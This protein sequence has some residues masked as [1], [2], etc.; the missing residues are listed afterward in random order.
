[1]D[2]CS[3]FLGSKISV[4]KPCR[5][6]F[7]VTNLIS[8]SKQEFLCEGFVRTPVNIDIKFI[9]PIDI[10]CILINTEVRDR[11]ISGLKLFANTKDSEEHL[12]P[13]SI[14]K[15]VEVEIESSLNTGSIIKAFKTRSFKN[16]GVSS[17]Q[18]VLTSVSP[19]GPPG[20]KRLQIWGQPTLTVSPSLKSNIIKLW[21]SRSKK[22]QCEKINMNWFNSQPVKEEDNSEA[23]K[24]IS[25]DGEKPIPE[26]F[27]DI[28][29]CEVM[30]LPIL[31]PSGNSI[32]SSSLEKFIAIEAMWGRSPSDPFT[33]IPFKE[34]RKPEPNILLKA[35]IDSDINF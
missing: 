16:V 29:T 7:S 3:S 5:D 10:Y 31:L 34:N 25:N 9:L 20:L 27:L 19:N 2:F 1:M 13:F 35:R 22:K 28:L 21:S 17:L 32:D 33:G 15:E 18:L 14:P 8:D 4:N 26:E 30:R 6:G 23:V 24:E 12:L 11:K